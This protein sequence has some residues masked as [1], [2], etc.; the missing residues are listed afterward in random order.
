LSC[1]GWRRTHVT[2]QGQPATHRQPAH[3]ALHRSSPAESE[4]DISKEYRVKFRSLY[5]NL[6]DAANELRHRVL[7]GEVPPAALVCMAPADLASKAASQWRSAQEEK[8]MKQT[9]L[10]PAAAAQFSTAAN[11]SL[12]KQELEEKKKVRVQSWD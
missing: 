11:R 10:D 1:P 2:L 8:A 9:I 7:L 3:A 4:H 6:R 12:A 5:F